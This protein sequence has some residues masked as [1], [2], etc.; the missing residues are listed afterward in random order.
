GRVFTRG[1]AARLRA[2]RRF[3]SLRRKSRI[4]P[5]PL[6]T[7]GASPAVLSRC[8]SCIARGLEVGLGPG[9]RSRRPGRILSRRGFRRRLA[10]D[11][12]VGRLP[13]LR[14]GPLLARRDAFGG[15]LRVELG[16]GAILLQ[17]LL[18]GLGG[19]AGAVLE[20]VVVGHDER[21]PIGRWMRL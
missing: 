5:M 15:V 6:L 14:L 12:L 1:L 3:A 21:V 9:S 20:T 17:R 18:P 16:P 19:L 13:R 8:I 11:L 10:F 7:L 4:V 2:G